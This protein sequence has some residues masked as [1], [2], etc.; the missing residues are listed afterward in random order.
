MLV[1]TVQMCCTILKGGGGVLGPQHMQLTSG[2]DYFYISSGGK[3]LPVKKK[4][5][6][7]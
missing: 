3:L 5:K 7:K 6:R 1:Q 2:W 4:K